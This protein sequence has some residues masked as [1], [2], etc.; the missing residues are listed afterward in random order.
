[1]R[2]KKWPVYEACI[3]E[4]FA[5]RLSSAEAGTLTQLLERMLAA[6]RGGDVR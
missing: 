2:K 4:Y 6:A 1:M 3:E 5:S